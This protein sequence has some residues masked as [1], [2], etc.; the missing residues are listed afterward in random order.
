MG[1]KQESLKILDKAFFEQKKD[2]SKRTEG[3]PF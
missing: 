2:Q 3:K 1:E